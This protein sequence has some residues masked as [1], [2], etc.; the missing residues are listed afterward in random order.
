MTRW[1]PSEI[2]RLAATRQE[3]RRQAFTLV[4]LLVVLS[5]IGLLAGLTLP[6]V[7]MA[8]ESARRTSCMS[9][10]KQLGLAASNF[11]STFKRYPAGAEKRTA[12]SWATRLLPMLEQNALYRKFDF[13]KQWSDPVN[14]AAWSQNL[15][16]FRCPTS[17]KNYQGATDYCG[18]S[19]SWINSQGGSRNG[20]LFTVNKRHP[21]VRIRDITDGLSQTIC[22]AEGVAVTARNNGYWASGLNCFS[23]DDGG[24]NNLRG[25]F[26]EIAS[27]HPSGA[28]ALFCDGSV[29]FLTESMAPEIV[30]A[31]CTRNQREVLNL[32]F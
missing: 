6:A 29:H 13:T 17:W 2:I 27:L 12:H 20:I 9:N 10:L 3:P 7:Q 15:S 28:N 16:V 1:K 21:A 22:V 4:E 18:I 19:G 8:R 11:E 30:G 23:H 26:K 14:S 31:A 25:G 32:E 24:V 5:I